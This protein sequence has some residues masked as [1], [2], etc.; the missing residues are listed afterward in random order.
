M[1]GLYKGMNK[2]QPFCTV[3]V[4]QNLS[5]IEM[6]SKISEELSEHCMEY[7]LLSLCKMNKNITQY[8][9]YDLILKGMK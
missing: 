6:K 2:Q 1:T 7:L 9:I 4:D 5:D 3:P 8:L